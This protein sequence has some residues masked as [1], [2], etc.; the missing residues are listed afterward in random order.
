VPNIEELM[1]RK[2]KPKERQTRLVN[3]VI[4]GRIAPKEFIAF[5]ASS[6]DVD[7]GACAD[8]MKHISEKKPELLAPYIGTLIGYITY[9]AP[10]VKWGVM[11]AIGNMADK[12]PDKTLKAIPYLLENT[13][14]TP[15]NSTVVR[16]CAAYAL[17]KIIKSKPETGKKM[18]PVFESLIISEN[19]S[20]VRNVY[21]M[22]M[23]AIGK[24]GERS[25]AST[26]AGTP[27]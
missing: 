26:N 9:A 27:C 14:E 18:A 5:F 3:A 24:T 2:M 12:Y 19:N 10:R 1:R 7:K 25:R 6:S 23:K 15:V 13:V 4:S 11:E 22:A 16:W 20:G 17:S 21:I 8:A